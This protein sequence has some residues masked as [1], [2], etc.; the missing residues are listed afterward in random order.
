MKVQITKRYKNRLDEIL[1]IAARLFR[2][3]G[4]KATS[5]QD[6]SQRLGLEKGAI[7][8]WVKSKDEILHQLIEH[9]G[10]LFL[11]MIHSILE[12]NI[13]PDYKLHEFIK[14]HIKIMTSNID[15]AT[16]FF[17][18]YK[19]LPEKWKKKVIEFRDEYESILRKIIKECQNEGKVRKDID[20]K[21]IGFAILG[22]INWVY[23]WFSETGKLSADEVAEK[24]CEIIMRGIESK[25]EQ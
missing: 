4:F 8:Y 23:H 22:M 17:S 25:E 19:A 3:K 1:D 20:P 6:I 13:P 21:I 18:E 15:K 10:K 24:F 14:N 12:K 16:V 9:E 2:E 11:K 5:I 7:Y